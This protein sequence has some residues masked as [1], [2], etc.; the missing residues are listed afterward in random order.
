LQ[1]HNNWLQLGMKL[2]SCWID[3]EKINCPPIGTLFFVF[4]CHICAYIS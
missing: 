2:V 4:W 3:D 1:G